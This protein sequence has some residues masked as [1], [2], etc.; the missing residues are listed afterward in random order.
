MKY[1]KE[2]TKDFE[3]FSTVALY[4][5]TKSVSETLLTF[6]CLKTLFS[7]FAPNKPW[8]ERTDCVQGNRRYFIVVP[9]TALLV[10]LLQTRLGII[11]SVLHPC[12]LK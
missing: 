2:L 1:S 4:V 8:T 12:L 5:E 11:H 6:I 9:Y 7:R 10:E 3:N